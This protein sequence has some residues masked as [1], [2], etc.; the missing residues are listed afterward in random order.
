MSLVMI[1]TQSVKRNRFDHSGSHASQ[2]ASNVRCCQGEDFKSNKVAVG[3]VQSAG[4]ESYEELVMT[5]RPLHQAAA[6]TIDDESR[7]DFNLLQNFRTGPRH[8]QHHVFDLLCL[9]NRDTMKLPP[10]ERRTLLKT[11][12]FKDK[13]IKSPFRRS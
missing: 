2:E 3:K 9:D 6:C 10:I 4:E 5:R 8:V 13:G 11:L 7:A 1:C 12:S